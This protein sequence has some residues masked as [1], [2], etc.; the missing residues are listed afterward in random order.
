M[1]EFWDFDEHKNYTNINIQGRDYKV[2][3]KFPYPYRAADV[4]KLYR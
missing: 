2:I 1:K 3:K 4:P